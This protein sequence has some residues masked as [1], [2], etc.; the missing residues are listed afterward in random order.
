LEYGRNYASFGG[1]AI[2]RKE[3]NL[4]IASESEE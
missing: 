1:I 4:L 2:H 3:I